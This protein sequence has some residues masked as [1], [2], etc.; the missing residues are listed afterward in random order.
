MN[1][2][3]VN[4][5]KKVLYYTGLSTWGL[6]MTLFM[7]IK[8]YL[9][10][11]GKSSLSPLQQIL[12]ILNST[13]SHIFTHVINVSFVKLKSLIRWSNKDALLKTMSMVFHK[14]FPRCVVIIDCFEILLDR[15]T[16]L[17]ARAQTYS[18]YKPA[19]LC[20]VF[21]WKSFLKAEPSDK[22]LTENSTYLNNLILGDIILADR[23]LQI[24]NS[25]GILVLP[26][27]NSSLLKEQETAKCH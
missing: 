9:H 21:N 24:K 18:S 6:L 19:I 1:E 26:I 8:P 16:N 23:G 5:D 11:T 15:P 10:S 4:D 13:I 17:L 14:N 7:Y 3:Y 20:E 2:G 25:V 27:R 22:Y 12:I